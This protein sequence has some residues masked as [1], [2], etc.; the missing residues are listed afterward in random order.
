MV[1]AGEPLELL[2]PVPLPLVPALPLEGEPGRLG[3]LPCPGCGVVGTVVVPPWP[4][5]PLDAG[6]VSPG[7]PLV[8]P[9]SPLPGTDPVP[10]P[11]P[12]LP[13]PV[14]FPDEGPV[15]TGDTGVAAGW[16]GAPEPIET[17]TCC[18][19]GVLEPGAPPAPAWPL[20]PAVPPA[21]L[22]APAAAVVDPGPAPW[23]FAG[24]LFAPEAPSAPEAPPEVVNT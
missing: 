11:D 23:A 20:E 18:A 13:V 4:L 16:L 17:W 12:V 3:V 6:G 22:A 9:G 7:S 24:G 1:V 19:A 14:E 15:V 8:C 2:C 21:V 5:L 10:V